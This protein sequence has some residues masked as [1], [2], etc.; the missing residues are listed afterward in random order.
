MATLLAKVPFRDSKDSELQRLGRVLLALTDTTQDKDLAEA[1]SAIL[2][3]EECYRIVMLGFERLLW[4]CKTLQSASI[5]PADL[6]SDGVLALT[7]DHLPGAATTFSQALD[8][9]QTALFRADVQRL[10]D[11]RRFVEQAASACDSNEALTLELM[12]RHEDVQRGKFD[13]GRRKMPWLE[14]TG[15][16]ISLTMTRVGG[17]NREATKPADIAPH[18][19]R[20]SSADALISAAEGI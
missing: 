17:L 6:Q 7:R 11:T 4:L 16:R 10:E 3:Y 12:A 14:T 5:T 18:P 9:A 15:N 20:L 8:T 19:Y 2:A 13:R 1:I